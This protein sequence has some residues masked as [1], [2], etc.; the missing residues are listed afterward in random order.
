MIYLFIVV[1]FPALPRL[2]LKSKYKSEEIKTDQEKIKKE[3]NKKKRKLNE[4]GKQ[5]VKTQ[6]KSHFGSG[7]GK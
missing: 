1:N 5:T 2:T 3:R 6:L 4:K 7:S